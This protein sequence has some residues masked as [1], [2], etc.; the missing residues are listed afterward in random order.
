MNLDQ[1]PFTAFSLEAAAA[2]AP[3][4]SD[5]RTLTLPRPAPAILRALAGHEPMAGTAEIGAPASSGAEWRAAVLP[6]DPRAITI[7]F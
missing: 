2:G 3:S 1:L 6:A 5:G 4:A 7:T